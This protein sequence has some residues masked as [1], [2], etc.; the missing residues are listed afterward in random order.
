MKKLDLKATFVE[1]ILQPSGNFEEIKGSVIS[2]FVFPT[3]KVAPTLLPNMTFE[4]TVVTGKLMDKLVDGMK[5][6][7]DY[8]LLE[9]DQHAILIQL[10]KS[11]IAKSKVNVPDIVRYILEVEKLE[12]VKIK[13]D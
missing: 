7:E 10:M 11:N 5:A 2:N 3:L 9:D 12:D 13:A 8:I 1:Q 4:V 6:E